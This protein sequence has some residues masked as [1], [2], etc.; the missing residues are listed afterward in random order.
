VNGKSKRVPAKPETKPGDPDPVQSKWLR[1]SLGQQVHAYLVT[2]EAV[3]GKLMAYDTQ[4]LLIEPPL[5]APEL[6]FRSAL[7][8]IQSHRDPRRSTQEQ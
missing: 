3:H 7:A 6:V 1:E 4:S 5:G 8:H 2:G